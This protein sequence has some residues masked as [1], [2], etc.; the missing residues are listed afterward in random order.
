MPKVSTRRQD[1]RDF[2]IEERRKRLVTV[3]P[4]AV[5]RILQEADDQLNHSSP[6]CAWRGTSNTNH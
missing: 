1:Q 6:R 2:S 5:R 4:R 3:S